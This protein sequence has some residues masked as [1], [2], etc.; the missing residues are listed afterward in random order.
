MSQKGTEIN[1]LSDI[2]FALEHTLVNE[3]SSPEWPPCLLRL[4]RVSRACLQHAD[5]MGMF[6][7]STKVSEHGI[8][9]TTAAAMA[10]QLGNPDGVPWACAFAWWR[11]VEYL[12]EIPW[13]KIAGSAALFVERCLANMDPGF[14]PGDID[15]WVEGGVGAH[16]NPD[17][18]EDDIGVWDPPENPFDPPEDDIGVWDPDPHDNSPEL[19]PPEDD[20]D[21]HER[22]LAGAL[23]LSRTLAFME[24]T[25]AEFMHFR[26][27]PSHPWRQLPP[28]KHMEVL[29]QNTER[30]FAEKCTL[31]GPRDIKMEKRDIVEIVFSCAGG[32]T[33]TLQ[34]IFAPYDEGPNPCQCNGYHQ[35]CVRCLPVHVVGAEA[36]VCA[37]LNY[38]LNSWPRGLP[39][40]RFDLDAACVAL[41]RHPGTNRLVARRLFDGQATGPHLTLLACGVWRLRPNDEAYH[42]VETQKDTLERRLKK[43]R[44]R[45]YSHITVADS[46]TIEGRNFDTPGWVKDLCAEK[47]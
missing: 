8:R 32:L 24:K 45:G 6:L 4:R 18:P 29:L 16:A 10:Q 5:T 36:Q 47:V 15:V 26:A 28:Q 23:A 13:V 34:I 42:V 3:K 33:I 25:E 11:C 22:S 44:S 37:D 39:Q 14:A 38:G 20:I 19:D 21:F 43:Y 35:G 9:Q 17:P 40:R 41:E 2:V 12:T 30:E 1:I 27:T 46:M 31:W 7:F